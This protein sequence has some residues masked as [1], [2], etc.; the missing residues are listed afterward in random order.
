MIGFHPDL[1]IV[2]A[3][4]LGCGR[5]DQPNSGVSF[6]RSM[7]AA[8]DKEG[9]QEG[10]QADDERDRPFTGGAQSGEKFRHRCTDLISSRSWQGLANLIREEWKEDDGLAIE[11]WHIHHGI[12]EASIA[13]V[14]CHDVVAC[15]AIQMSVG[16]EP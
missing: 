4:L 13:K 9:D 3:G 6:V 1:A 5:S 16:T 10:D 15:H 7:C 12:K 11:P 8:G 2:Y 14:E